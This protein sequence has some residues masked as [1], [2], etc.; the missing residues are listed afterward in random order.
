M[1]ISGISFIVVG[2]WGEH[3]TYLGL[4]FVKYF[5]RPNVIS[6]I[7]LFTTKVRM[8]ENLKWRKN[9]TLIIC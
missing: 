8:S 5:S 6:Y 3:K 9:I 2:V 7:D 4:I 1:E